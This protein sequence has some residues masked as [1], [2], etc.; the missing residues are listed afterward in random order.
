LYDIQY[1]VYLNP[2]AQTNMNKDKEIKTKSTKK[3]YRYS[4]KEVAEMAKCSVSYV[5]QIRTGAVDLKS[6]KARLVLAIDD[7]LIDGNNKLLEE[8]ERI[9]NL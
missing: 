3:N 5:K 1:S 2:K 8:V 9:L 4:S 6:D 7:I